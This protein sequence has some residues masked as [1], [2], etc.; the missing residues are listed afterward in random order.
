MTAFLFVVEAKTDVIVMVVLSPC[1][2]TSAISGN[3]VPVNK[4]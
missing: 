3:H 1:G 2:I 4:L